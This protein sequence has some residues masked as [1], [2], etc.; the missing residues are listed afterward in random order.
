LSNSF[1]ATIEKCDCNQL[2]NGVIDQSDS[3]PVPVHHRHVHLDDS[4][5]PPFTTTSKESWLLMQANRGAKLPVFSTLNLASRI[6]KPPQ[7]F[8]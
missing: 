3:N 5:Y 2:V 6:D 4:F 7:I 1:K 8:S